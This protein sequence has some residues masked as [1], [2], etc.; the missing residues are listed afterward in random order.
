MG[1]L[2]MKKRIHPLYTF[3]Q[4]RPRFDWVFAGVALLIY[5]VLA[6]YNLAAGSIWFDEAFSSYIIQFNFIDIA[7]Y[8]A[9]DVHPPFYYWLL[10]I[11][12]SLFGTTELGLRSMSIFFGLIAAVFGYLWTRRT[13][14]RRA[15]LIGL[16]ILALSPLFIRYSQEARMYTLSAAI[17]FAATYVMTL[18]LE[19]K[20]RKLWIWYGVLVS[21]GMWTHYFT[22]LAW[23]AHWVWRAI[24]LWRTGVRK[25]KFFKAFFEKN[26]VIAYAVAIGLFLPWMPAMVLQLIFIQ[27]Q[28]FWIG[29]VGVDTVGSYFGTLVLFLQS[30]QITGWVSTALIFIGLV[31]IL[32]AIRTYR[33]ADSTAR[34]SFGLLLALAAVPPVV[35]F[36]ASMP[37]LTSSFVE[38]YLLPAA[39]AS[40]LFT[41]VVFAF[42]L[43][44][45]KAWKQII[46]YGITAALLV[47]GLFNMYYY[48]NYNKNSRTGI[49]TG[50]VVKSIAAQSEA[51]IPII[52]GTPWVFYEA[53]FYDTAEHPVHFVDKDT[54]YDYGSLDMLKYND[55]HKIKDLDAFLKEH[56]IVWYVTYVDGELVAPREGWTK[57]EEVSVTNHVDG[58]TVYKAGK[59]LTTNAE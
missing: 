37:P 33:R 34:R 4:K 3:L 2:L 54:S 30:Y 48:G 41:G 53:V 38:R 8:T 16:S 5:V 28:G 56:P 50:A 9:T 52:A 6:L 46:V 32:A 55:Q 7:R 51:G 25:K 24:V 47:G 36:I 29:D 39:I 21:L 57:L 43:R 35:L 12:T 13:F 42:G 23:I 31:V 40:A 1:V 44:G 27:A 18:A 26:W 19:T 59:F 17:V 15:A 11:W 14:G 10:K 45:Q 20:K 22:A 49:E 58:K